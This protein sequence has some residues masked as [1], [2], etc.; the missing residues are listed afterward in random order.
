MTIQEQDEYRAWRALLNAMVEVGMPT[1][2]N[3][4]SGRCV[5]KWCHVLNAAKE[6]NARRSLL[7]FWRAE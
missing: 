2:V 4:H 5:C 7:A 3:Q 6:W 1:E